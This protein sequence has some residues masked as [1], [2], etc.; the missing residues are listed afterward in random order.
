MARCRQENVGVTKKGVKFIAV[1]CVSQVQRNNVLTRN[2][3][4]I[5]GRRERLERVSPRRVD[6]G[7][8][9]AGLRE[10][11][12][13]KRTRQI[14]RKGNN[15]NPVERLRRHDLLKGLFG[16]VGAARERARDDLVKTF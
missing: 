15:A 14:G 12:S 2:E 5:P 3:L 4:R 11:R 6:L 16:V 8:M 13:R 9:R 7:Y 10:T 1:G